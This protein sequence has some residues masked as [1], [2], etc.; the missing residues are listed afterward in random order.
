METWEQIAVGLL[1]AVTIYFAALYFAWKRGAP[2]SGPPNPKPKPK[3]PVS[4]DDF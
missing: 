4:W 3:R 1:I 2:R